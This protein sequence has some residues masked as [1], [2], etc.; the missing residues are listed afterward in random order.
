MQLGGGMSVM[1]GTGIAEESDGGGALSSVLSTV[2]LTDDY[3]TQRSEPP[4]PSQLATAMVGFRGMSGAAA[5]FSSN[6]STMGGMVGMDPSLQSRSQ[7]GQDRD[8]TPEGVARLNR[9]GA[10][11][12]SIGARDGMIS[13]KFSIPHIMSSIDVRKLKVLKDQFEKKQRVLEDGFE[14]NEFVEL[15]KKVIPYEHPAEETDLV[16][17]AITLFN[18]IDINGNG[19]MEWDEFTGFLIEAVDQKQLNQGRVANDELVSE[20]AV[21]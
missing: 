7:L 12:F 1:T 6:Q 18:E 11:R 10:G 15:M 13:N 21:A 16:H 20:N 9:K 4:K 14:L 5:A 2:R 3:T 8:S 17:G 19:Y